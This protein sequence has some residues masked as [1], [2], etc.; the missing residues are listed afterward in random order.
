MSDA[1]YCFSFRIVCLVLDLDVDA[2]RRQLTREG[3]KKP[4][5]G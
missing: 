1:E 2:V 3:I 5:I 4:G